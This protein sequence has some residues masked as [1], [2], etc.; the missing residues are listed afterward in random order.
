[1]V[2]EKPKRL[3]IEA[4]RGL[5]VVLVILYHFKLN[6]LNYEIINGGFIGV[7]IFF[8]ISGFV[9]TK[10]ISENNEDNFSLLYFYKRRI[11]RII[12]LLVVV[13]ISS[14]IA[15]FFIFD[16]FLFNKNINSFI[17]TS[18]AVSNLYFW[19]SSVLYQFAEQ[20]NLI[21]LHFWSLSIEMQ[22]YILF[23]LLFIIFRNRQ[24]IIFPIILLL[25][26]LSYLFVI[27][28]YER[29]NMFNFYNSFSRVF[30]F[31]SGSIIFYYSEFF[32]KKTNKKLYP[33]LYILGLV[34]LFFY[35]QYLHSEAYHP[36]PTTLVLITAIGLMITFNNE[37]SLR[38]IKIGFSYLGKISY[39]L[40]LW[41]FPILVLGTNIFI[42]FNDLKKLALILFCFII[43]TF[44]YFFIE[45]KFREIHFKYSLILFLILIVFLVLA[46]NLSVLKKEAYSIFNLD[47]YYL[48]D[49]SFLYLKNSNKYSIRKQ[50][51]IFSFKND[52]INYSPQF[53][54]ENNR[55]NILIVGDS[56]ATDLFNI[57]KT[58]E[59]K[60][61]DYEF[62][63]Y[64]INLIDFKNYR[65]ENFLISD[66]FKNADYIFY[67]QR[68]E[69]EDLVYLQDIIDI[70]NQNKKKLI[71]FLKRP[72]FPSNNQKNQTVLDL[73]YLKNKKIINK[74]IMDEFMF[75]QLDNANVNL[76]NEKIQKKYKNQALFYDLY[77]VICDDSKR[78]C[79]SID[80]EGKKIFY[81]YG[82]FTLDGSK[83][84]GNI[85]FDFQFHKNYLK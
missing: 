54:T 59:E 48:Q 28:I 5:S 6:N 36:S 29:H 11:K 83:Y 9:I 39:S 13:L 47:N 8:V 72:E 49:E 25:F 78:I 32:R 50:K 7:D 70:A 60:F 69:M 40:Y 1:M 76:I 20:N 52:S 68:Y 79:N 63:R 53:N 56:H 67:S 42:E 61:K 3:D 21:N 62:A 84:L 15:I 31:L 34:I 17:A 85:L 18:S 51:N 82:H 44:T 10:I 55:K 77:Q 71:I 45:K 81:D 27:Q 57:F 35:L 19:L 73:F 65:K 33:S 23:P 2:N 66:N 80:N 30:E 37:E 64:G 43:S 58:N 46:K 22:F 16:F 26:L 4:L 74:K 38:I 41:H 75:D 14:I 12:P 24:K